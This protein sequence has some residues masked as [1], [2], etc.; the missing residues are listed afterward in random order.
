M[1]KLDKANKYF[2]ENKG[3]VSDRY[4]PRYHAVVPIGWGN[5]PNGLIWYNDEV[6]M[7]YQCNPYGPTSGPM[8]WGHFK[9]KDFIKWEF[10]NVALA[11]EDPFDNGM[12][13]FSGSAI[14]KDNKLYLIYTGVSDGLQQQ[15][16]AFSDDGIHFTK[17]K[18]NPVIKLSDL[19][20]NASQKDFRDPFVIEDNGVYYTLYGTRTNNFGNILLYKSLDLIHWE[21]VGNLMNN[22]REDEPN[23]FQLDGVY[24][25]PAYAQIDGH[26]ILIT[27]ALNLPSDGFKFQNVHC[28]IYMVGKLN[29]DTGKFSYDEFKDVDGGFDYY[30]PQLMK[31]GDGRIISI[32]WKEMWGRNIPNAIDGWAGTYTLPRELSFIGDTLYQKPVREIKNYY[33][34]KVEIDSLITYNCSKSINGINGDCLVLDF[35]I[36]NIESDKAGVKIFKG[37][38]NETLIYYDSKLGAIVFDRSKCGYDYGGIDKNSNIRYQKVELIDGKVKLQLFLDVSSC[39]VFINDGLFTMTGNIFPN[40]EEDKGIEFFSEGGSAEFYNIEKNDINI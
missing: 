38:K 25:C 31:A 35:E 6:H 3:S 40:L 23:F 39:E 5:D 17:E 29:K 24:E 19:P 21:Y 11:P 27:S 12:G 9:S 13:C 37:S 20:K 8:H 26:E 7:F 1:E 36:G 28:V 10:I 30:A 18:I 22:D 16:V 15:C 4:K 32:A 34:N 33:S 2:E 14:V